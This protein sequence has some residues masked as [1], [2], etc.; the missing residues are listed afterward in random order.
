MNLVRDL[1]GWK[2][3]III[4]NKKIGNEYTCDNSRLITEFPNLEFSSMEEA[5]KELIVWYNTKK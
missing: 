3:N 4:E 1:S 5:I 2:G